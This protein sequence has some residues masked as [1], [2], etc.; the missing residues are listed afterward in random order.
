MQRNFREKWL[1][2]KTTKCFTHKFSYNHKNSC[3]KT[4]QRDSLHWKACKTWIFL[5]LFWFHFMHFNSER[6]A[7]K[8]R[9]REHF[10]AR[11][12]EKG[13][14]VTVE[15]FF[16]FNVKSVFHFICKRKGRQTCTSNGKKVYGIEDIKYIWQIKKFYLL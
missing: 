9:K 7:N 5:Y 2:S 14:K 15:L 8:K 1:K 3:I 4:Y 11:S 10:F 12:K 6:A 13:H 16:S